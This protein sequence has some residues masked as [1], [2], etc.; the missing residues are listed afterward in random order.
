MTGLLIL[1]VVVLVVL[2]FVYLL[3]IY[4]LSRDIKGD[5]EEDVTASENKQNAF[6]YLVFMVLLFGGF[7]WMTF[8][9]APMLLP[10]SASAH[11]NDIDWLMDLNLWVV[12][13]VFL[14]VNFLLF[15]FA[16]RFIRE[17]REK[18]EY[19]AH[20]NKLELVWTIIPSIFL[21]IVIIYGLKTWTE[22]TNPS[23]ETIN[24]AV[25]LEFYARQFDWT[26]RYAGEDGKLGR[27]HVRFVG[28][29]NTVGIDPSDPAG[30]DDKVVAGDFMLP[31]GQYAHI[32]IRSQDVIHSA[33]MPHF[34][35]Q[36]NAVPGME[37]YLT[38]KPTVTTS[39][40]R[41]DEKVVK[42]FSNINKLRERKGEEPTEFDYLLICNKICGASHYNMKRIISVV[43]PEEFKKWLDEK[44]VFAAEPT[45][46][47]K[48]EA[49]KQDTTEVAEVK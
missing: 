25:K 2:A 13:L 4:D 12:T 29:S 11:G 9:Y 28:G 46:E 24:S 47:A 39:E 8:E 16:Y 18:A 30:K 48:V 27:A 31:V 43:S 20:N 10:K 32:Q 38:F 7:F 14:I 23:K 17:N 21:A 26:I 36:I 40:M 6:L 42:K 15:T 3:R 41:M 19:F 5:R 33:F 44:P 34:R 35:A 1:A 22:V 49:P 37:T 45:S